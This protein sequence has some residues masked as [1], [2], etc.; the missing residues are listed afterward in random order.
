[1]GS[2]WLVKF[3]SMSLGNFFTLDGSAH[4]TLTLVIGRT[5]V[6]E[7]LHGHCSNVLGKVG[8]CGSHVL[9]SNL[10]RI[11][12]VPALCLVSRFPQASEAEVA[13][14]PAAKYIYYSLGF[15][16][17]V[18]LVFRPSIL[19]RFAHSSTA[20]PKLSLLPSSVLKEETVHWRSW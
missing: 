17:T 4:C 6:H 7:G 11:W 19:T 3:Q 14:L 13:H 8:I 1:M 20:R 9:Q 16:F 2:A 15:I 5:R 18:I 10:V 12:R